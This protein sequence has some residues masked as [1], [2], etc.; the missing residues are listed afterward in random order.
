[1]AVCTSSRTA[2]M[3][4]C[5]S[6]R[7]VGSSSRSESSSP[8]TGMMTNLSP[9]RRAS[10]LCGLCGGM[11]WKLELEMTRCSGRWPAAPSGSGVRGGRA[12][13][14][15]VG[16]L[17]GVRATDRQSRIAA[18]ILC[19]CCFCSAVS[20]SAPAGGGAGE[21][22][23]GGGGPR[24]AS[25]ALCRSASA[26]PR[27]RSTQPRRKHSQMA[28]WTAASGSDSCPVPGFSASFSTTAS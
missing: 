18:S 25:A 10:G 17:G 19:S 4:R 2:L 15:P 16:V 6:G 23:G 22:G 3:A 26:A 28:A 12:P 14:P 5:T 7:S 27:P 13:P 20:G 1:M 21:A 9:T 11:F 24:D 8:L